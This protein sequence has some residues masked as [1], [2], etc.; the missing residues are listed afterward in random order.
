MWDR[1]WLEGHTGGAGGSQC[2]YWG[3]FGG[4]R[5][6]ADTLGPAW[7]RGHGHRELLVSSVLLSSGVCIHLG[8]SWRIPSRLGHPICIHLGAPRWPW[9]IPSSSSASHLHPPWSI[10]PHPPWP[11]HPLWS[12]PKSLSIPVTSLSPL[13]SCHQLP[14]HGLSRPRPPPTLSTHPGVQ[15]CRARGAPASLPRVPQGETRSTAGKL[16]HR[17]AE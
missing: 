8:A 12:I 3:G 14:A 10:P 15:L 6:P 16:R 7:Q 9:S 5:Y 4:H 17:E 11:S 1:A 13:F 2:V